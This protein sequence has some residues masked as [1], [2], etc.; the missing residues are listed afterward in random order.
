MTQSPPEHVLDLL[1]PLHDPSTS[2]SLSKNLITASTS[3]QRYLYK[4]ATKDVTQLRGEAESLHR[5]NEACDTVAPTLLGSGEDE[6]GQRWMLSEWHGAFP[7][8]SA[9]LQC[10]SSS[11]IELSS[12][13]PSSFPLLAEYLAKMHLSPPPSSFS[14]QIG[15]P[16]PTYCGVTRM[17][18]TP[19]S[20]WSEFWSKRRIGDM[21]E[22]IGDEEVSKLGRELQE[23]YVLS[24]RPPSQQTT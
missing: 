15:F 6:D 8:S 20:N 22:R 3:P 13:P 17:D 2:F 1:K 21:C 7:P 18:N 24:F 12:I 16:L 4:T 23:R 5:M 14:S 19:L 9:A 10:S 11:H